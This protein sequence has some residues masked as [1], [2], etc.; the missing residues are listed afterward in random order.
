MPDPAP[1]VGVATLA[2]DDAPDQ[3]KLILGEKGRRGDPVMTTD[4][5]HC[6]GA[7]RDMKNRVAAVLLLA[8]AVLTTLGWT[9]EAW[10]QAKL[11]RVGILSFSSVTDESTKEERV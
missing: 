4:S 6:A 5:K 8:G 7:R 3:R 1:G 9:G 10:G 2:V 11:P